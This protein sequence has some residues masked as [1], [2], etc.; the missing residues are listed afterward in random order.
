MNNEPENNGQGATGAGEPEKTFTQE[1]SISQRELKLDA[2]ERLLDAGLPK[3]LLS[4]LNCNSKEEMEKSIEIIQGLMGEANKP[5][6]GVYRAVVDP[7]QVSL[8]N[9]RVSCSSSN[10]GS[11][12]KD[13]NDPEAIRAAMGLK[14]KV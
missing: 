1:E 3:E 6:R 7:S 5:K 11:P 4:A 12:I 10:C 14:G 13:S 2:R 9:G 8:S